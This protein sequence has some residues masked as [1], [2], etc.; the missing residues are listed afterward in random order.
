MKAKKA[1]SEAISQERDQEW[2]DALQVQGL[3]ASDCARTYGEGSYGKPTWIMTLGLYEYDEENEET[4]WNSVGFVL[5][6]EDGT[7]REV[8]PELEGG[9]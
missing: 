7:I 8:V 6:D 4:Y 3:L 1:F 2:I 5:L 9:G